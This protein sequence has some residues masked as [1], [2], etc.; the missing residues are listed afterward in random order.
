MNQLE[1]NVEGA[2]ARNR[3]LTERIHAT[4]AKLNERARASYDLSVSVGVATARRG[5]SLKDALDNADRRLYEA[6]KRI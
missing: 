4:L 6:K 3:T 2:M 1:S 5:E